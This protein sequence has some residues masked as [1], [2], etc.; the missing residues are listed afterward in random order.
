MVS[1][2]S[3]DDTVQEPGQ[4]R[5]LSHAPSLNIADIIATPAKP[6]SLGSQKTSFF[7]WDHAGPSSSIDARFGFGGSDIFPEADVRLRSRSLSQPRTGSLVPSRRGSVTGL[8]PV[9]SM[10]GS[11]LPNEDFVF[12]GALRLN[13]MYVV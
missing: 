1:G 6:P 8:S 2:F 9:I 7:P 11:Q 5:H 10:H 13:P 4:A 3:G 12:D